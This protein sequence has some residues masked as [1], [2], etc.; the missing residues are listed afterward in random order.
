MYS[1]WRNKVEEAVKNSDAFA[2]FMNMCSFQCML[3]EIAEEVEIDSFSVMDE[4][5]PDSLEENVRIFDKYL[6]KYEQVYLQ[7]GISVKRYSDVEEF[8]ADYLCQ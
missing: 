1:N 2:S 5:N 3:S 8:V 4:Y 7:A 6:H